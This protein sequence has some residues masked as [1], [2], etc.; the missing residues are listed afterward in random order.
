VRRSSRASFGT[1]ASIAAGI[2]LSPEAQEE[3]RGHEETERDGAREE[4]DEDGVHS[5]SQ[6]NA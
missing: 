1:P 3:G 2:A 4:I 6:M 5:A